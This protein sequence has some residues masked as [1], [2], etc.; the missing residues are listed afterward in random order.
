M[1]NKVKMG[2]NETGFQV[3]VPSTNMQKLQDC[4]YVSRKTKKKY[5]VG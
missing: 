3:H 2:K 5:N 4:K 1:E